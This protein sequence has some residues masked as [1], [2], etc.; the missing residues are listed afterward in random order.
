MS[1][2]AICQY[3]NK[4]NGGCQ[5]KAVRD[6]PYCSN[7]KRRVPNIKNETPRDNK[8]TITEEEQVETNT[9]EVEI[10]EIQDPINTS[11][12]LDKDLRDFLISLIDER[13]NM[14]GVQTTNSGASGS[15][16]KY[17]GIILPLLIPILLKHSG[18]DNIIKNAF[19][20]EGAITTVIN[21]RGIDEAGQAST[22]ASTQGTAEIQTHSAINPPVNGSPGDSVQFGKMLF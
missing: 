8:I 7:H 9:P 4:Y 18:I 20:S 5:N 1:D 2:A 14:H 13:I 22:Q 10:L 6:S 17:I 3:V 19:N 15:Y 12:D 11:I 16:A 21:T